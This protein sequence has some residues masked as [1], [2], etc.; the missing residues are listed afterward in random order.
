[1]PIP[2]NNEQEETRWI[3]PDFCDK[4]VSCEDEIAFCCCRKGQET[5]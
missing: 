1:M 4:K 3:Q 2:Q 5:R